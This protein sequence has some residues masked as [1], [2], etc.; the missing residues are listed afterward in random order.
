MLLK[1]LLLAACAVAD[2]EGIKFGGKALTCMPL[3]QWLDR[4]KKARKGVD[5][6]RSDR[7]DDRRP[8]ADYAPSS[9][10]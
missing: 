5:D 6:R 1:P 9:D 7:P 4:N 8:P 2:T 3:E 10:L